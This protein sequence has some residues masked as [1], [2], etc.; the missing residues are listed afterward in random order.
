M[1]LVKDAFG[2]PMA[3]LVRMLSDDTWGLCTKG[4]TDWREMLVKYGFASVD[5]QVPVSTLITEGIV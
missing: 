5:K 4:D 1:I 2:D 3:L